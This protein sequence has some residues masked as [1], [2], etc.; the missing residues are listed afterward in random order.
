MC[1]TDGLTPRAADA[2]SLRFAPR[3]TLAVRLQVQAVSRRENPPEVY[4]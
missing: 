4:K 3:P 1:R 2:A